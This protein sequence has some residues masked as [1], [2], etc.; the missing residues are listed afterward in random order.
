MENG[1][2]THRPACSSSGG[3]NKKP[4]NTIFAPLFCMF[5]TGTS[6]Y[7]HIIA[8]TSIAW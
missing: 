8:R 5:L 2:S 4:W 7:H 3:S 1:R 6:F